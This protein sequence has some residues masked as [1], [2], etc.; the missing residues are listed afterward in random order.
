MPAWAKLAWQN[1]HNNLFEAVYWAPE[2][3]YKFKSQR[4]KMAETLRIYEAHVGMVSIFSTIAGSTL[5]T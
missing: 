5:D 3:P 4:P 2:E 1:P